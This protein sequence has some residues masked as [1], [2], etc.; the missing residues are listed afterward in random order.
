MTACVSM[1]KTLAAYH[2]CLATLPQQD[3]IQKSALPEKANVSFSKS[4]IIL[5]QS[6]L[7]KDASD[8][9]IV[10]FEYFYGTSLNM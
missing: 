7:L 9:S 8:H 3:I 2:I 5:M 6:S 1:A 4:H 10:A